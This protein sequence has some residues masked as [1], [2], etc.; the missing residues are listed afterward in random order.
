MR[1]LGL[2]ETFGDFLR[3]LGLFETFEEVTR[4]KRLSVLDR[5]IRY[6]FE[7]FGTVIDVWDF[8]RLLGK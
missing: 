6:I 1:L 2:H 3:L 4:L 5:E 8:L 7:I